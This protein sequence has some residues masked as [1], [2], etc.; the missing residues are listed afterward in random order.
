M[1]NIP[2]ILVANCGGAA[3]VILLFVF[4]V[5]AGKTLRADEALYDGMLIVTLLAL[6]ADTVSF[7]I[8]GGRFPGCRFF[9]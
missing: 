3:M 8:D 4:R 5:R 1:I 9:V 6:A 2:E 7:L